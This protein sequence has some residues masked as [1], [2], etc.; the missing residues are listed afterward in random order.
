MRIA[1]TILFLFSMTLSDSFG[2]EHPSLILTKDGV[3]MILSNQVSPLFQNTLEQTRIQVDIEI[4]K[5]IDVPIPKDMAGGYT[6]ERHRLNYNIMQKAGALYQLTADERYAVYVRDMLLEYAEM[7]PSLSIHPTNRS[8]STGKIFWQCLNDANWLVAVAQAYDCIY[9]FL[10]TEER[11]YIE[12]D[13][14]RPYADFISVEN[15]QFFNRI[16]NHSTWGN[17]AVG[18]I[19]LAIGDDGLVQRALY[20]LPMDEV[21]TNARDNDGGYIFENG[22]VRAGFLA[23]LDYAFSPDGYYTEG[24]YYQRYAMTP[25]MIFAQA[26]DNTRPGLAIFEYRDQILFKAVYALL[27]QTTKSGEFFSINDSQKGMSILA[28]PV[29]SAV[30]I[31]YAHNSDPDLLSV[32]MLQNAIDLDQN[33]FIVSKDIDQGKAMVMKKKSIELHDGAKGDE[34]AIAIVRS[35]KKESDLALVFKYTGQGLG[36]GH[37]DKLSY[38]LYDGDI[39]VLQDYGAARWVNIDQKDGGRYLLENNT[40]AKQSISHNTVVIDQ[41]SHFNGDY[42]IAVHEHSDPVSF[43]VSDP[44]FQIVRAKDSNAYEGS[45]MLR[46][47]IMVDDASLPNPLI[48]DLFSVI[49][50]SVHQYDLAFQY[51]DHL[52]KTNIKFDTDG[53]RKTLGEGHGYQH[54]WEEGIGHLD[55]SGYQ[56]SWFR[57]DHFYTLTSASDTKD[58]CILGR[59]GANDPNFNLRRDGVLIHRKSNKSTVLFANVIEAHGEYSRVTEVALRPYPKVQKLEILRHDA[60]YSVVQ[61][62]FLED[63]SWIIAVAHDPSASSHHELKIGNEIIEWIGDHLIIKK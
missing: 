54:L 8:Y 20:G 56:F 50:D 42:A 51:Q 39:E 10:T 26:L 7:F 32:A 16:H 23:Q 35:Q 30:D 12:I 47:M 25:F 57:E 37:Y 29:I 5:G 43:D 61:L 53:M 14:L 27:Y 40:W 55:S 28:A 63:H 38:A 31:V 41:I 33:G 18:M 17:A 6:H 60:A 36:H 21:D 44:N 59:L 22:Q 49:S 9:N 4:T 52:L 15:P 62:S 3:E 24:P 1:L 34:G 19:G 13:L 58:Q 11:A 45:Q 46:T 2:L 48:V